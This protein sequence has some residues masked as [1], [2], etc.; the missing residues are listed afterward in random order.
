M[1]G[2]MEVLILKRIKEMPREELTRRMARTGAK[3]AMEKEGR[4]DPE[5]DTSFSRYTTPSSI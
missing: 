1:K 3:M 4:V 5:N 2:K